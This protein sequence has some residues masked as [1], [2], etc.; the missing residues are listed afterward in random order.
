[1]HSHI[2]KYANLVIPN[3]VTSIGSYSFIYNMMTNVDIGS[4]ITSI[5]TAAFRYNQNITR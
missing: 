5:Q 2:T 3:T 4:G 1:M